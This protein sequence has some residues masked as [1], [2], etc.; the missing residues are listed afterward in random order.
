MAARPLQRFWPVLHA[1]FVTIERDAW[2]C[3]A[4]ALRSCAPSHFQRAPLA[5][6]PHPL[7]P[8]CAAAPTASAAA[9]APRA[10]GAARARRWASPAAAERRPTPPS[11][12]LPAAARGCPPESPVT[13]PDQPAP[14]LGLPTEA[15]GP[16]NPF[17]MQ[18]STLA[19]CACARAA[20]STPISALPTLRT[21]P[22]RPITHCLSANPFP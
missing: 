2:R 13:S 17:R 3:P 1:L 16:M 6:S 5:P 21:L 15:H 11:C 12:P 9:T 7:P 4:A 14:S 18:P 20:P 8:R 19:S 22:A 10:P